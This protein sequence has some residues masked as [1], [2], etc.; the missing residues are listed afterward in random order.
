MLK[1]SGG[2]KRIINKIPEAARVTFENNKYNPDKKVRADPVF[3]EAEYEEEGGAKRD[4][5]P[6]LLNDQDL[7][8]NYQRRRWLLGQIR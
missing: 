6:Q 1:E 7:R 3:A 8:S 4:N 2:I 5:H